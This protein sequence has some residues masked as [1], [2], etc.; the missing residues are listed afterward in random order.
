M[1]YDVAIAMPP[2]PDDDKTAWQ[3]L[4]ERIDHQGNPGP[5]PEIFTKL[6]AQLTA[7]HP[8]ICD[9]PDDQVDDAVWS[10][11]PLR[12]NFEYPIAQLGIVYSRA[13][14]VMP[15]LIES[16]NRWGLVVFDRQTEQVHRPGQ[17]LPKRKSHSWWRFWA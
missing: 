4:D 8:C 2:I 9:L 10:D 7:R 12:N 5:A 15:F 11:G 1:S 14:E 17:S 16:A 3:Q 13:D 6:H